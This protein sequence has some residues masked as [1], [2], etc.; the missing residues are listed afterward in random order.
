[1]KIT[2]D[3]LR[4]AVQEGCLQAGQDEALWRTLE[5]RAQHRVRFDAAHVSYYIGAIIVI[6][7]MGWFIT[8]AWDALPGIALAAVAVIYA[9]IFSVAGCRLW[10]RLGMRV[11]GGLLLTIAVS[12]TPL[13]LYGVLR[14][15]DL[16]PQGN[17]GSYR[18]LHVWVKGSWI[19]LELGT[20]AAG[21]IALRFRRF[22]FLTAPIAVALWYLSMDLAPLLLGENE[23]MAQDRRWISL[24]FGL[25]MLAAA[26]AVDLRGRDEDV[27]FWIYLFGLLAFWGGLSLM[28]SHSE[29]GKLL[30]FAINAGLI[31]AALFLRRAMF[32]VFGG[33]GCMAYIGHL[34]YRV[35]ED[36]L[37][38]PLAL[39][40]IGVSLI[41]LGVIYQRNRLQVERALQTRIPS[42]L[43]ALIPPRARS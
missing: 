16:W 4:W 31:F 10:D 18:D 43:H 15:L 36:S 17:P 25:A 37:L 38:F 23:V 3:D 6:A 42:G 40:A 12:M 41:T 32:V 1:M 8:A 5:Q 2:R 9:A 11:P 21:L 13:A 35:F 27:A 19:T 26:Y 34:A 29:L 33:L 7:A 39:T 28:S 14:Q 24:W 30:Y 20:I 22:A